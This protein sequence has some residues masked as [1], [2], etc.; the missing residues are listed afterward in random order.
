METVCIEEQRAETL[1]GLR[2]RKNSYQVVQRLME[3]GLG[4]MLNRASKFKE[5]PKYS[6]L[7]LGNP[8]LLQFES[9]YG[10]AYPLLSV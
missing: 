5:R 10:P 8:K 4:M 2:C 9:M 1:I 6:L 7:Q 3:A